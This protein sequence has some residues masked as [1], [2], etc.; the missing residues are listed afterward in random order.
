MAN[1][2]MA[3]NASLK[4]RDLNH[5]YELAKTQ[6]DPEHFAMFKKKEPLDNMAKSLLKHRIQVMAI[7]RCPRSFHQLDNS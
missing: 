5:A 7:K 1:L 2:I 4:G 3:A 6:P